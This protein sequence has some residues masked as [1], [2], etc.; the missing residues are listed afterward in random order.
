MNSTIVELPRQRF[1]YLPTKSR[2][3]ADSSV[4]RMH[5]G[6]RA[7]VFL[8]A[9]ATGSQLAAQ[10]LPASPP[11]RA[12]REMVSQA[13]AM[14]SRVT[15]HVMRARRL[16]EHTDAKDMIR[17]SCINDGRVALLLQAR[18]SEAAF[19]AFNVA[20]SANDHGATLARFT[21]L[22]RAADA[23]DAASQELRSCIGSHE[24]EV[25]HQP[26][27]S[28]PTDD[29]NALGQRGCASQSLEYVTVA[30]PFTPR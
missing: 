19:A 9:I 14:S 8:A 28:D 12:E 20:A 24:V 2:D 25:H 3:A 16:R 18:I 29:C 27:G 5:H 17:L 13:N 26:F 10:P 4:M 30:S 21:A 6:A 1:F 22:T 23:A 11:G 7:L 15:A